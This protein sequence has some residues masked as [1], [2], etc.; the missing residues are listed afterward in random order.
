M[1][2]R[3]KEKEEG[4]VEYIV[5]FFVFLIV[6]ILILSSIALRQAKTSKNYLDDGITAS[7]LATEIINPL[8][9]NAG[10]IC[11]DEK[12]AFLIFTSALKVNLNLSDDYLSN[13]N[14]FYSSIEISSFI[15]Y[16]IKDT[17]VYEYM[18]D[19]NG[20]YT[21][22]VHPDAKGTFQTPNG[23]IVNESSVYAKIKVMLN[24]F[25]GVDYGEKYVDEC[26]SLKN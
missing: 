18:Y 26:V 1:K 12:R 9:Y 8:D 16:N 25:Y 5:C 4:A 6:L 22:T 17:D 11:I 15:V 24:D 20:N 7:L 3:I 23:F 21:L 13:D 2:L 10:N 19:L 14:K